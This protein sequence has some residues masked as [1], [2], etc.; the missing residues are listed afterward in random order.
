MRALAATALAVLA[1]L[2]AVA[3]AGCGEAERVQAP[4]KPVAP[5]KVLPVRA[6]T[7][8]ASGEHATAMAIGRGRA[9]TVAHVLPAGP[10]VFVGRHRARVLR[11]DRRLDL[12]VLRVRGLRAPA[13]ERAQARAGQRVTVRVRRHGRVRALRA[14]VRR[15]IVA[16]VTG[17]GPA[18]RRPAL[19]LA[20]TVQPGDSGAPVIDASGR[21]VGM[22]FAQAS[23]RDGVAYALD[24]R[25]LPRLRGSRGSS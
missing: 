13:P 22:V 3:L 9:L 18:R 11:A 14:R 12:G 8:G 21:V 17:E 19:E 4:P 20:V 5:P 15:T 10:P 25:A 24:A 16:R 7:A 2:A 6:G 23:D 1:V